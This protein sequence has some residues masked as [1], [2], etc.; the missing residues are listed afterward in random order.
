METNIDS[1]GSKKEVATSFLLPLSKGSKKEVITLTPSLHPPTE[2]KEYLLQSDLKHSF[3]ESL[4]LAKA[5]QGLTFMSI[6]VTISQIFQHANKILRKILLWEKFI[7]KIE[8]RF[9]NA[10]FSKF[11]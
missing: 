1:E 9:C 2:T 8:F 4:R 3:S 5:R 7:K 10:N 6:N 11:P